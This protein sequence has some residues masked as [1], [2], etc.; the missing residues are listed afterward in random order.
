VFLL[1]DNSAVSID[2]RSFGPVPDTE[3]VGR[4]RFVI[5]KPSWRSMAAFAAGAMALGGLLIAARRHRRR[6]TA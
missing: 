1:G 4:V 2:S 6:D 5:P 3:L